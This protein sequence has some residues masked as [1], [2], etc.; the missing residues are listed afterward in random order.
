MLKHLGE[1][2]MIYLFLLCFLD[3]SCHRGAGR[4]EFFL[5]FSRTAMELVVEQ[6]FLFSVMQLAQ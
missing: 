1:L 4:R 5:S 6:L 2:Q 3:A